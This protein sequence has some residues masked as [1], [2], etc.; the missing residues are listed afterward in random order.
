MLKLLSAPVGRHARTHTSAYAHARTHTTL[1]T[2]VPSL[3]L[4]GRTRSGDVNS[5]LRFQ[6]GQPTE[7]RTSR[8][9]QKGIP[10]PVK[11]Q[12]LC[13]SRRTVLYHIMA[14]LACFSECRNV[15]SVISRSKSKGRASIS[16][17]VSGKRH[18]ST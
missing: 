1:S 12:Q 8:T 4:A 14:R 3:L 7:L 5:A 16:E 2:E 9:S 17:L 11:G 6:E 10:R 13:S 18:F 15:F